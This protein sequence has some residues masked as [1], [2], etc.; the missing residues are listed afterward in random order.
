MIFGGQQTIRNYCSDVVVEKH[1]VD[2]ALIKF[3]P[4]AKHV[5]KIDQLTD[6]AK[7]TW[8]FKVMGLY[9]SDTLSLHNSYA[10]YDSLAKQTSNPALYTSVGLPFTVRSWFAVTVVHMWMVFVRL[11]KD[12]KGAKQL[13]TDLYDRFWEDLETRIV[14]G[15]VNPRFAAK[16]LK[17]FYSAYLGSVISYDEGM[18]DD[19]IL[20]DALWR[21]LLAMDEQVDVAQLNIFVKYIRHQLNHLDNL[22]EVASRG[23]VSFTDFK[24]VED[25]E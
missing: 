4:S 23:E 22:P 1:T 15:G 17:E 6:P 13:T 21:N 16:Y 10:I 11:R 7:Q 9:S 12:G 2:E 8:F 25:L 24:V 18:F 5:M 3:V 20:A 14:R 19:T